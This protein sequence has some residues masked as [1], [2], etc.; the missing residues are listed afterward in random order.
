MRSGSSHPRAPAV[1]AKPWLTAGSP[2]N[3][4]FTSLIQKANEF[5]ADVKALGAALLATLEKRDAEELGRLRASHETKVLQL[6][7]AAREQDVLDAD[8]DRENIA[9]LQQVADAEEAEAF[10]RA[11]F[12]NQELYQWMKQQLLAVYKQAYNLAY[13]LAKKAEEA[14]AYELGVDS[15][16]FI[17]Y[18]DWDNSTEGLVSGEKLQLA[19]R[20]LENAYIEGNRRELELTKSVSLAR[21]DPPALIELRETGRCQV[22]LP[23]ELFDLDFPG[24]YFRRIRSVRVAMP[25]VAGPYTAV[26]CSLRLLA[27]SVRVNSSMSSAGKYEHENDEGLLIDDNRFRSHEPRVTA[28]ATNTAQNDSGAFEYNI[29][30]E[31]YLPFEGAGAISNWQ[32]EL[33][34]DKELRQF[35][36]RTITDVVLHLSYTAQSDSGPFKEKATAHVID[37]LKNA[38]QLAEQPFMQMVSMKHEFPTEW[39]KFLH[40]AAEDT[41]QLLTITL[42]KDRFPFLAQ[43]RTVVVEKIDAFARSDEP[44]DYQMLLTYTDA[45]DAAV[46]SSPIT[47]AP[48]AKY[49]GVNA[50][51]LDVND[52]GLALNELDVEKEL[53]LQ[54]KPADYASLVTDPKDELEDVILVLHYR[55]D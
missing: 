46:T 37:F 39:H 33:S 48:N 10:R 55:L 30:E 43:Q 31:R 42:G 52:A 8:A 50:A 24:H 22:S 2:P 25:C 15:P 40:P 45:T 12:T 21:L 41:E 5:C 28:I 27:N 18:E 6:I 38:A 17:E 47:L 26:S 29:S 3:Y 7:A 53:R 44:T 20:E 4:R 49:G 23:E 9:D 51:T 14:Y 54:L 36:Y 35:D 11:K 13:E 16:G 19:L 32:L 34:T 1:G